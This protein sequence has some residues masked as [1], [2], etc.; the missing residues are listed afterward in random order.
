MQGE[1]P[2][3]PLPG[4]FLLTAA[5]LGQLQGERACVSSYLKMN[6]CFSSS[7]MLSPTVTA[8]EKSHFTFSGAL[9]NLEC[10]LTS[11]DLKYKG[12]SSP[13]LESGHACQVRRH[14]EFCGDTSREGQRPPCRRPLSRRF[15]RSQRPPACGLFV[16]TGSSSAALSSLGGP[17]LPNVRSTGDTVGVFP[18]TLHV[19]SG[20][21][22]TT[23]PGHCCPRPQECPHQPWGRPSFPRF[24]LLASCLPTTGPDSFLCSEG[25]LHPTTS[26]G[27]RDIPGHLAWARVGEILF[28][29]HRARLWGLL[30]SP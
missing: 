26:A 7:V 9:L 8:V 28:L 19:G 12:R 23:G 27:R 14:M 21:A 2:A 1:R 20:Q 15:A 16:L 5:I 18:E 10:K 25:V 4:L 6:P 3:L 29:T 11:C 30:P 13:R 22:V 24:L 17:G